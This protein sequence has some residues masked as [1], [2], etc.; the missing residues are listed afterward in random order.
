MTRIIEPQTKRTEGK[1]IQ[2]QK[3][4]SGLMLSLLLLTLACLNARS[5]E[6]RNEFET[7][8]KFRISKGIGKKFKV[9]VKPEFRLN[10][11]LSTDQYM[12]GTGLNYEL[13]DWMKLGA[14]YRFIGNKRPE[15][16]TEFLHR[17]A[18]DA[19][20]G[21][22]VGRF[23]P[24]ARIRYTNF[25]DDD[26]DASHLRYKFELEYDIYGSKITPFASVQA[27]HKIS[28]NKIRKIRYATGAEYQFSKG[29]YLGL[30]YKYDY[31]RL[32]YRNRHILGISYKLKL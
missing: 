21:D 12:I 14:G 32:E 13:Y 27:F 19:S 30:W 25:A 10:S 15:K 8:T 23:R 31:Y 16:D 9:Y 18:L 24:E 1:R 29:N 6:T 4:A 2:L 26:L 5:Q 3:A 20:F 7:W 28:L 22:R 11:D 17:F